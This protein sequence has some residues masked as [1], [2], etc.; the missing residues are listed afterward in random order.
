M[1]TRAAAAARIA[2]K[3]PKRG[4]YL[5]GNGQVAQVFAGVAVHLANLH[6]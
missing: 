6:R 1:S 4:S 3:G 5:L 2:C